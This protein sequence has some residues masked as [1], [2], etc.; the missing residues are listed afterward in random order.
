M[1]VRKKSKVHNLYF[2]IRKQNDDHFRPKAIKWK[3][4]IKIGAKPMNEKQENNREKSMEP[5]SCI[6]SEIN[7]IDKHLTKLNNKKT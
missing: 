3:A 7:I 6:F 5:E 4:A 2:H 1:H